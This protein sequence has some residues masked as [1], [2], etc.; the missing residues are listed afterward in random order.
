MVPIQAKVS[1]KRWANLR[2]DLAA[3][4][5]VRVYGRCS[6]RRRLNLVKAGHPFWKKRQDR[7]MRDGVSRLA[8]WASERQIAP[9]DVTR[10]VVDRF[11]NELEAASLVRKIADL[12]QTIVR[13]WNRLVRTF[14]EEGLQTIAVIKRINGSPRIPVGG[15]A[16]VLSRGS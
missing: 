11:I 2:S 13:S 6:G 5:A 15:S 10:E 3:A 9:R 8:R 12:G 4:I 1:R 16:R 14:P 7:R